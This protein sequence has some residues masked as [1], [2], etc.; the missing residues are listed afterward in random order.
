MWQRC[1]RK[2]SLPTLQSS[3]AMR[4]SEAE[5]ASLRACWCASLDAW[6][7]ACWRKQHRRPLLASRAQGSLV[8]YKNAFSVVNKECWSCLATSP[9]CDRHRAPSIGSST[10]CTRLR[11]L[12]K[13]RLSCGWLVAPR[14]HEQFSGV[15]GA[16]RDTLSLSDDF[17]AI[18]HSPYRP[19]IALFR[20]QG[21]YERAGSR[22]ARCWTWCSVGAAAALS[23]GARH[24]A[25]RLCA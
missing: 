7:L 21:A 1:Q 11:L 2:S 4:A 15:V 13:L 25:R 16:H 24:R 6:V 23:P 14:E 18:F 5:R 22:R 9:P 3:R 20:I 19:A 8:A 17:A 10:S 12:A